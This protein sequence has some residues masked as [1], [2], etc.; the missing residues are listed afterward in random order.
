MVAFEVHVNGKKACTAGVGEY[1]V[2][3]SILSMRKKNRG[4]RTMWLE[5]G[6]LTKNGADENSKHVSWLRV[7]V[8]I[9]DEIRIRVIETD[10]VDPPKYQT[11]C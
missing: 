10:S 8:S 1:G 5:V 4:R 2:M 6:G 3:T 11:E 7:R 9:G